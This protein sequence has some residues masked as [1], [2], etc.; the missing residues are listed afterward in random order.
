MKG[1]VDIGWILKVGKQRTAREQSVIYIHSGNSAVSRYGGMKKHITNGSNYGN[2]LSAGWES[3]VVAFAL[4]INICPGAEELSS[5][6]QHFFCGVIALT[7][8]GSLMG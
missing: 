5:T 1:Y 8:L 7:W 6:L 2:A 4:D 3:N